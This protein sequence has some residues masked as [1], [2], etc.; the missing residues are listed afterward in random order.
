MRRTITFAKAD[1]VEG[2]KLTVAGAKPYGKP[3]AMLKTGDAAG[4]P[5]NVPRLIV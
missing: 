5:L 2:G 1:Q 3:E 4:T